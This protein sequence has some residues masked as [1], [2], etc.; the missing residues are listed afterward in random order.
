MHE[1]KRKEKRKEGKKG[2]R[3]KDS[4]IVLEMENMLNV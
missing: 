1:R 4:R 2:E 3:N